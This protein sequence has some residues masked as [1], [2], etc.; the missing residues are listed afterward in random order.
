MHAGVG[1]GTADTSPQWAY[2]MT[3]VDSA[4]QLPR[5]AE[6]VRQFLSQPPPRQLPVFGQ[7]YEH[8]RGDTLAAALVPLCLIVGNSQIELLAHFQ[9]VSWLVPS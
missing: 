3:Y 1:S 6:A 5:D 8:L 7:K 2:D 4:E 9:L